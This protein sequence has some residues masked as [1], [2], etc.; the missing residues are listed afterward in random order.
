MEKPGGLQPRGH[1]EWDV[2]EHAHALCKLKV[3][4]TMILMFKRK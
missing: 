4:G 1:A 2:T 3:Y